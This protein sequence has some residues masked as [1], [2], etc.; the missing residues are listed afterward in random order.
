MF[1]TPLRVVSF[2]EYRKHVR[3]AQVETF[4]NLEAEIDDPPFG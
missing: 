2:G 4:R 1:A 3:F